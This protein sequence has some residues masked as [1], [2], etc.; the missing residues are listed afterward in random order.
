MKS[1]GLAYIAT[2]LVFLVIDAIWL[3]VAAQR[4][5]RP[6]MGEMLLEGFR[7][8]PAILFYVIYIGGIVVFA[9]APAFAT[10]RWTTATVYGAMLGLFAY[11]TYDLTNQATLRN[12]PVIV[13][14]V[15]LSWGTFLTALAA[16]TGFLITRAFTSA[17]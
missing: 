1:Y 12:W 4:F 6:L 7:L 9:I 5:Y 15:D 13:T 8:I 3:T 14:I 17:S 2:G 10:G 16:T 11:A